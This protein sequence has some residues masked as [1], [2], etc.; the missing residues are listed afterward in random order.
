LLP[1]L[2]VF[3]LIMFH[4]ILYVLI[5]NWLPQIH[6]V[7]SLSNCLYHFLFYAPSSSYP[8]FLLPLAFLEIASFEIL[9][10]SLHSVYL[11]LSCLLVILGFLYDKVNEG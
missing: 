10:F 2:L 7:H 9:K 3:L 11:S 4:H 5:V 8:L 6:L 1:P